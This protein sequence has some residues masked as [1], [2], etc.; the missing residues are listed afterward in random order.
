MFEVR[1]RRARMRPAVLVILVML[2]IAA[3]DFIVERGECRGRRVV[4]RTR[5]TAHGTA[6]NA[7]RNC[8]DPATRC[9]TLL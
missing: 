5:G 3:L 9:I 4:T 6:A 8:P 7:P 1:R 2:V